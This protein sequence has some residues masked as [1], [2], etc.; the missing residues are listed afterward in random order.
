MFS[1]I[2]MM[3]PLTNSLS[4]LIKFSHDKTKPITVMNKQ[5]LLSHHTSGF[6]T[7]YLRTSLNVLAE[8]SQFGKH[9]CGVCTMNFYQW[10]IQWSMMGFTSIISE[11]LTLPKIVLFWRL[12]FTVISRIVNLLT[13]LDGYLNFFLLGF[14]LSKDKTS[15]LFILVLLNVLAKFMA[16]CG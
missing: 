1:R 14:E 12:I 11:L 5:S 16:Y 13:A 8:C 3:E 9:L 6:I 2:D 15:A 4:F 10:L 7:V